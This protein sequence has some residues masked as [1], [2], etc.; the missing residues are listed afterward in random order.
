V[1]LSTLGKLGA[2]VVV[3]V[4][5]A[6][7]GG[8]TLIIHGRP[9]PLGLTQT[10][11]RSPAPAQSLDDPLA[12]TCRRPAVPGNSTA[13]IDGLWT[14]Q[15]GSVAGYRA[16][17]KFAELTS[18][19]EAVARTERLSGWILVSSG[20]GSVQLLT[21]CTAID[22]ATLRSVDELPGF[23]T[24]DRDRSARDM[25][26]T[27]AHP[28]AVFQPYPAS[29]ALDPSSTAVQHVRLSGDLEVRG[30]TLRSTFSLDLRLQGNQLTAAGNTVVDVGDF[31]VDVPQAADGFVRVDP[32]I[33]LEVSLILL[34][35]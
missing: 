10:A 8:V 2:A 25:L 33:T 26:R 18:P 16:H 31:G 14:I 28:F 19:H 29:L 4:A 9:Q 20:G 13:G 15:P 5:L 6:A 23:D 32:Q 21:G 1:R 17:E 27:D 12:L 24:R 34:K 22:V 7:V 30:F 11:P 35:A 3:V